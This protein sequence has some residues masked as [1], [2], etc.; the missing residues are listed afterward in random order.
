MKF[1]IEKDKLV[2]VLSRGGMPLKSDPM[3][4][5]AYVGYGNITFAEGKLTVIS[6]GPTVCAMA[7]APVEDMMAV[8][9][10]ATMSLEDILSILKFF[11]KGDEVL[12]ENVVSE[13]DPNGEIILKSGKSKFVAKCIN[14]N[15]FS[16]FDFPPPELK[17]DT[18]DGEKIVSSIAKASF[19]PSN[20]N[21]EGIYNNLAIR[22][23]E[24]KVYIGGGTDRMIGYLL[25]CETVNPNMR[26]LFIPSTIASQVSK[27]ILPGKLEMASTGKKT[28]IRQEN[29]CIRIC[30][31][32][33]VEIKAKDY[34]RLI[35]R[36]ME[37]SLRVSCGKLSDF[38]KACVEVNPS[39]CLMR[40]RDGGVHVAAVAT[41]GIKNFSAAVE[42]ADPD[43]SPMPE[44]DFA[45]PPKLIADFVKKCKDD[46]VM[47]FSNAKINQD[48]KRPAFLLLESGD[49]SVYVQP[50]SVVMSKQG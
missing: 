8:E 24:G 44:Y 3:L 4:S 21:A 38:I 45:L 48:A 33:G 49:F 10:S 6:A 16:K 40:I 41:N 50:S 14:N 34:T 7:S 9:G 12:V 42:Y 15:M 43:V 37:S 20:F 35:G 26:P 13:E 30:L 23:H 27:V 25:V 32:D 28:F 1:R 17:F 39:E 47:G 22:A 18:F 5:T 29:S 19:L 46:I 36:K 11:P 2:E 31:P